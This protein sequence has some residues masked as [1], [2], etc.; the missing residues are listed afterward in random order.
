MVLAR[1]VVHLIDVGIRADGDEQRLSIEREGN[2]SR[3][4]SA[5][6]RPATA[7]Q[8]RNHGLSGPARFEVA[9]LVGKPDH[10]VGIRHVHVLGLW[11]QRVERYAEGFMQSSG[12]NGGLLRLAVGGDA[13]KNL[14]LAGPALGE[15][16]IA[17]RSGANQARIL[18]ARSVKLDF[19]A[20]RRRRPG[21][22]GALNHA[23]LVQR[24]LGDEGLW[25]IRRRDFVNCP[26]RFPS[27]VDIDAGLSA[28]GPGSEGN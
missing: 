26:W 17:V 5:P 20:L 18:Q 22:L 11:T 13:A 16:Q 2:V 21:V 9:V 14:D 25:Q 19:E 24:G 28:V 4:V 6:T 7:W 27:K 8:V 10:R 15:E 23:R 1:V 12:K 3:P